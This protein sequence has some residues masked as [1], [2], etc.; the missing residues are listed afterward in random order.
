MFVFSYCKTIKQN[1]FSF[2][3]NNINGTIKKWDFTLKKLQP[4][5][6][7]RWDGLGRHF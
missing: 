2:N 1:S 4:K 6:L 5:T 3:K 7:G